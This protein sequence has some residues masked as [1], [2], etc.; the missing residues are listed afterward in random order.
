MSLSGEAHQKITSAHLSRMAYLYVR[1]STLRQV[2]ENTESTQRQYALRER[3][4]ALGWPLDR[5]VVIDSDLGQSAASATDREGFQRLVTE[6]S[7]G[8]VGIVL[9][10][11]VSRLARNST[12]WHRLL[13]LCAFADTLILDED[14]LYDP[15]HFNDRLLLGLKGTMSEAE[16]HVLK[17]R[18]RGGVL[19]RARRGEL[20]Q[21]VPVGFV[22]DAQDRVIL[23]PDAQVQAAVRLFFETFKRTGS[24]LAVVKEFHARDLLFPRRL[25]S[26]PHKGDLVWGELLHCRARQIIHNPRYTGAFVFGRTKQRHLPN[27]KV[28]SRLVPSEEW[29]LIRDVHPGYITW[30]EYQSNRQHVKSNALAWSTDRCRGPAREGTALLQGLVICGTCG[31][32]MTVRYHSHRGQNIPT[33]WCGRR[34][35]QRGESGLCQTV[36]GG[37]LDAAIGDLI[38]EAMTPLAIEVALTVQQELVSRHEEADRLRRQHVERARYEADLAQRRFL[39]VD[40]DNRLVAD[41]LEADWNAKLRALAAAQEAYEKASAADANVVTDTERAE[42]MALATDFPRLWHDPRTQMKEKKRMLRLLIE[43]VTLIKGDALHI[44]IRFSGGATRS[45]DLPLP[46]SCVELRTTDAE[47]VKEID[48]LIDTYT[49]GEI[50]DVLNERGVRTV[51]STPWTAARIGR[52]RMI[53]R[54]ADRRARLLGQG[55]LTPQ[56][57]ATRYGVVL[58]TVHLWRRRGLLRAHPINDRGDYLYEIPPEDLPAK[59]AH[60]REYQAEMATPSLSVS[61][62]AV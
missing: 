62:G 13:E 39:K 8:H 42:L 15:A 30:E 4:V 34:P 54:L 2:F 5:I 24:C 17:A 27:G 47:V 57:V 11:E 3:A 43:D 37:A 59:Y 23:D 18:L 16:L 31:E 50:A 58:S 7:L 1:Q 26:G 38:I 19:S 6:V 21:M 35:M 10:L 32:R 53:Y 49:D 36:H 28:C 29:I 45:V 41:A 46:K 55:L 44:D 51:V 60:K 52:L 56:D 61:R 14:G 33:Y 48:R 22:H 20:K 9:G 40:P 25:R 12:D